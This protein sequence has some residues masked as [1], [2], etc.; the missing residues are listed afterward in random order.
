M[1]GEDR[2]LWDKLFFAVAALG[3]RRRTL[4]LMVSMLGILTLFVPLVTVDPPVLGATHWSAFNIVWETYQGRLPHPSCERCGEPLV[5]AF[6]ALPVAVTVEYLILTFIFFALCSSCSPRTVVG[7]ALFGI[8]ITT[9]WVW[10]HTT[11]T[12]FRE[13]FYELRN[14]DVGTNHLI[15]ALLAVYGSLLFLITREDLDVESPEKPRPD[16][17]VQDTR[18]PEFLDHEIL[19]PKEE[20]RKARRAEN[21]PRMRS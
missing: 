6:L 12:E 20:E 1:R 11:R 18:Q 8:C 14:G 16:Y 21:P 13:T 2:D 10:H 19:P 3:P 7:V 5:R 15:L 9:Q 17:G 4:A